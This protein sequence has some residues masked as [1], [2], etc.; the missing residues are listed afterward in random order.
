MAVSFRFSA[1]S[2][3]DSFR[4]FSR[5]LRAYD[6]PMEI[7]SGDGRPSLRHGGSRSAG[8]ERGEKND[9]QT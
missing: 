3:D 8:Q 6:A 1:C 7:D 9:K 5:H 2:R 4:C